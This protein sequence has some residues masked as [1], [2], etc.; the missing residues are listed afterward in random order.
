[1]VDQEQSIGIPGKTNLTPKEWNFLNRPCKYKGLLFRRQL[2]VI[3]RLRRKYPEKSP[4]QEALN[5]FDPRTG[6]SKRNEVV[7]NQA[8][9]LYREGDAQG[10]EKLMRD[11]KQSGDKP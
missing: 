1:M 11:L 4:A 10:A 7:L 2:R 3:D 8:L 9:K 6:V 5:L